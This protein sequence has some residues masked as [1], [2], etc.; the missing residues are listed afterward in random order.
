MLF[1]LINY[2]SLIE[3]VTLIYYEKRFYRNFV[4]LFGI[5]AVIFD[6]RNTITFLKYKKII[7]LIYKK[8]E[9]NLKIVF[10]IENPNHIHKKN[11]KNVQNRYNNSLILLLQLEIQ[12]CTVISLS[13][14][15]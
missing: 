10:T 9:R 5:L 6:V 3:I 7:F 14:I 13:K 12:I 4:F 15:I 8:I 11:K 1:I 2:I